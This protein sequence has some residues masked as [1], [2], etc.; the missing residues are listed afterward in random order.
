ML[1]DTWAL[2]FS[3]IWDTTATTGGSVVVEVAVGS[4]VFGSMGD[5]GSARTRRERRKT[6]RLGLGVE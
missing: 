2:T 4:P 3:T 1:A 5:D 6:K